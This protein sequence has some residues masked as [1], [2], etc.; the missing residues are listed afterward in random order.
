MYVRGGRL[1][2]TAKF[3]LLIALVPVWTISARATLARDACS[4]AFDPKP[5]PVFPIEPMVQTG[6]RIRWSK[7]LIRKSLWALKAS[8]TTK[9]ISVTTL[10]NE[11]NEH[12]ANAVFEATGV[13]MTGTQLLNAARHHISDDWDDVLHW[14]GISARAE[15]RQVNWTAEKVLEVVAE[16]DRRGGDFTKLRGESESLVRQVTLEVLK[17]ETGGRVLIDQAKKYFGSIEE[18]RTH[19][20]TFSDYHNSV[21]HISGL[22]SSPIVLSHLPNRPRTLSESEVL[23]VIE[24]LQRENE[25][26]DL[27]EV[28][29]FHPQRIPD[30]TKQA[31]RRE[32]TATSF[33]TATKQI[34]GTWATATW[35]I[36]K[37]SMNPVTTAQWPPKRASILK[38]IQTM[39]HVGLPLNSRFMRNSEQSAVF[40]EILFFHTGH[41]KSKQEFFDLFQRKVGSF[42]SWVDA[43]RAAQIPDTI[44]PQ[45]YWLLKDIKAIVHELEKAKLPLGL[46]DVELDRDGKIREFLKDYTGASVSPRGLV[47]QVENEYGSWYGGL[48]AMGIAL[49][50]ELS[51]ADLLNT[52]AALDKLGYPLSFRFYHHKKDPGASEVI[53]KTVGKPMS[54]R[55][56][57]FAVLAHFASWEVFLTKAGLIEKYKQQ[58]ASKKAEKT[59]W[60]TRENIIK[61]IQTLKHHDRPLN[62][63]Y[64]NLG[65]YDP[66][67]LELIKKTVD[68]NVSLRYFLRAAKNLFGSWASALKASGIDPYEIYQRL[69]P[70]MII[71]FTEAQIQREHI[72]DGNGDPN[73]SNVLALGDLP[74]GQ[75][76][77][78]HEMEVANTIREVLA[79]LNEADAQIAHAL[80]QAFSDEDDSDAETDLVVRVSQRIGRPV[81]PEELAR[82]FSVLSS[83]ARV[84]EL[85]EDLRH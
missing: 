12:Q 17:N 32:T 70:S 57:S 77:H 81:A 78:V 25:N 69:G 40:E 55:R 79:E 11:W 16:I 9:S 39:Y 85:R 74:Q 27:S 24:L 2:R 29:F 54:A 14:A 31:L 6:Q 3:Y 65:I 68:Q 36:K 21:S 33:V 30:A 26:L 35:S 59:N 37:R 38:I 67:S 43:L 41:R 61:V 15:R 71:S 8:D 7:E 51:A 13:R 48:A 19:A 62:Y 84:R 20:K 28:L 22:A 56:F 73:W 75:E 52:I 63:S 50:P 58:L 66:V 4:Q 64:F 53:G 49:P 44:S 47:A 46:Y 23:A 60:I 5:G 76:E 18:A 82:T 1:A 72:T 83:N 80:L 42:V 45:G 34:F 10:R